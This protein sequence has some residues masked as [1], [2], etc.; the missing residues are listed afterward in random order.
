[1]EAGGNQ[2]QAFKKRIKELKVRKVKPINWKRHEN[3]IYV[4]K[5]RR[6]TR[7]VAPGKAKVISYEC[8]CVS[9]VGR[10][11]YLNQSVVLSVLLLYD[12]FVTGVLSSEVSALAYWAVPTTIG[13]H[14]TSVMWLQ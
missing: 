5:A 12:V 14:V 4:L 1:M 10:R 8:N 7:S 2:H 11:L 3:N 9:S 6:S 13:Y